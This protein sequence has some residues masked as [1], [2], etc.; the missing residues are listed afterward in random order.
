MSVLNKYKRWLP[1]LVMDRRNQLD[2]VLSQCNMPSTIYQSKITDKCLISFIDFSNNETYVNGNI[3]SLSSYTYNDVITEK[4][5][6]NNIG[7][8][9]FDNGFIKLQSGYTKDEYIKLLKETKVTLD[10]ANNLILKPVSGN[11]GLFSYKAEKNDNGYYSFNGGFLQG[12]YKLHDLDYNVLPNI[13][14]NTWE[15]EFVIRP[16]TDYIQSGTTLNDLTNNKGIFFYIGTRATNKFAKIYNNEIVNESVEN[17]NDGKPLNTNKYFEIETDNKYLF[18]NRTKN[19]FTTK[20]WNDE[21]DVMVLTGVQPS[22]K[23]NFYTIFNRTKNGVTTKTYN[24]KDYKTSEIEYDEVSDLKNNSFALK[25]NEDGS[26]GY[27]YL[28]KDCDNENGWDIKEETTFSGIVENNAWNTIHVKFEIINGNT[29]DCGIPLGERKMRILIYVNGYLKLVSKE[30]PEFNFR[31]L[32]DT[33]DKQEGV[34]FNISLGGGTLGL[35]EGIDIN[36]NFIKNYG[37]LEQNFAGSFIGDIMSFKFY[38]CALQY[39]DIRSNYLYYINLNED[40]KTY[41]NVSFM[42]D[43]KIIYTERYE[44]NIIPEYTGITPYKESDKYYSYEFEKWY[45][46]I[47]KVTKNTIYKAL[48]INKPIEYTITFIVDD[49]VISETTYHYNDC[50]TIPEIEEKEGFYFIWDREIEQ[51]VTKNKT[52]IGSYIKKVYPQLEYGI[53]GLENSKK[54]IDIIFNENGIFETNV[55]FETD[56]ADEDKEY[57]FYVNTVYDFTLTSNFFNFKI[58]PTEYNKN[59]FYHGYLENN[60][61][62]KR[63]IT[64]YNND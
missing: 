16:R 37:Y 25:I 29:D 44:E 51:F 21:E 46:N 13:I 47:N 54:S 30:L 17:S 64:I 59:L 20:T 52:Y 43:D 2:F 3:Q 34:P 32:D 57:Y 49:I 38:N 50:I 48:F 33:P 36:G 58:M 45:P 4:I 61:K 63:K 31:A 5:K 60:N 23:V 40:K 18:F 11:L 9:G 15:M 35:L 62:I 42:N 24:E 26:I 8:T 28:I 19:G 56:E 27:R 6:L 55:E 12:F 1:L 41:Y 7:F 14:E 53:Y 10:N 39:A 22:N